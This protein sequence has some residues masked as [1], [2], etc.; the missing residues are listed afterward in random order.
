MDTKLVQENVDKLVEFRDDLKPPKVVFGRCSL[1]GEWGKCLA[2]DLGDMSIQTPDLERGVE[3][4]P[5]TGEVHFLYWK[6]VVFENQATFSEAGLKKVLDYLASQENPIPG[7][8]PD[9]VYKWQV[10]YIDGTALSQFRMVNDT[11]EEVNSKE[12]NFPNVSQISVVSHHTSED[13]LPTY[14]FV[15]ETGKIYRAGVELDLMYEGDYHPD[16]EIVYARKV[17]HTWGS[18]MEGLDRN[19]TNLHSAVLQLLGWKIGGLKGPGPGL[20]IAIDEYGNWRP[21]EYI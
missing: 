12:I 5:E 14:T 1:T 16:A 10:L 4:D 18:Q 6:P 21:W 20:I 11:E 9:L 7:I 2:L 19:I 15:K 3:H 13:S 8:C 17:T